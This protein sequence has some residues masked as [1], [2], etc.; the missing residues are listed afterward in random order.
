MT[1]FSPDPYRPR[2]PAAALYFGS[3]RNHV[4]LRLKRAAVI[5]RQDGLL[6]CYVGNCAL[7]VGLAK[8]QTNSLGLAKPWN[9]NNVYVVV[10]EFID[11]RN[12]LTRSEVRNEFR[13][14][15]AMT[16]NQDYFFPLWF[17]RIVSS[18]VSLSAASYV[19]ICKFNASANG[20]AVS[21]ARLNGV[22]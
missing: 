21:R 15:V 16:D 7:P 17:L 4:G 2:P 8:T 19:F 14:R 11:R 1:V 5:A 6:R 20:C 9:G 18:T 10:L 12:I 22:V 13:Q 3:L